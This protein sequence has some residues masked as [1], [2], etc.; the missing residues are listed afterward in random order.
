MGSCG[1]KQSA[2]A[3]YRTDRTI[4]AAATAADRNVIIMD[5]LATL[6]AGAPGRGREP[7]LNQPDD[8]PGSH[9]HTVTGRE[10]GEHHTGDERRRGAEHC[11][12]AACRS[13]IL[14]AASAPMSAPMSR[15]LVS[16]SWSKDVRPP[17]SLPMN[18]SIP[19]M[20]PRVVTEQQ[21]AERRDR[22]AEKHMAPDD[23]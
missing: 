1:S 18:S 9:Q 7:G 11:G 23:A 22:R 10:R 5:P 12:P 3:A 2:A 8:D 4:V 13:A 17:K 15:M 21:A 16:S 19:E 6:D 20:T 14:P